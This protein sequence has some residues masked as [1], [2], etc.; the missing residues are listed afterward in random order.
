MSR[1]VKIRSNPDS[2]TIGDLLTTTTIG[3]PRGDCLEWS[4]YRDRDGYGK[5]S[6]DG[7]QRSVTRL[8]MKMLG[9]GVDGMVVMHTC[10]NPPCVNPLHLR[11]GSCADNHADRNAKRRQARGS[12]SGSARLKEQDIATIR[13]CCG[14]GDTQLSVAKRFGVSRT[15]IQAIVSKTTWRHL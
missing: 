3:G 7:Q 9:R 5:A 1:R 15:T 11:V 13:E 10:D 4:A 12:R 14:R 2:L 8:V 6:H